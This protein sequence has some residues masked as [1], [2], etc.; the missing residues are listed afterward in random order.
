MWWGQGRGCLA[1]PCGHQRQTRGRGGAEDGRA[2]TVASR[3]RPALTPCP[4]ARRQAESHGVGPGRPLATAT[5]TDGSTAALAA[6]DPAE[7]SCLGPGRGAGWTW[8]PLGPR[9]NPPLWG[10]WLNPI[11][12]PQAAHSGAA[13]LSWPA[14]HAGKRICVHSR[15]RSSTWQGRARRGGAGSSPGT[16]GRRA[17]SRPAAVAGGQGAPL[18]AGAERGGD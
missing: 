17:P 10:P 6:A 14:I 15:W 8:G 9:V 12:S 11:L 3:G 18:P 13:S 7:V 1:R 2:R 4:G 5:A 16:P